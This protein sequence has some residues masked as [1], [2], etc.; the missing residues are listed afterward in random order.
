MFSLDQNNENELVES[1]LNVN[2]LIEKKMASHV[3]KQKTL[4]E[5]WKSM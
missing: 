2:S 1:T 4:E 5:F 3:T